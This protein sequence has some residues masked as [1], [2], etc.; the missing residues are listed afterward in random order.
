MLLGLCGGIGEYFE[1]DPVVVR[2]I[3]LFATL[4]T[5]LLPGIVAYFIGAAI[6]PRR[7]IVILHESK[8][9]KANEEK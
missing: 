4:F 5:G 2:L 9:Q 8:A 1:I 6:V 7:P 3:Y